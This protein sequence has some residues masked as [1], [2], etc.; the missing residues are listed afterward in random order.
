MKYTARFL[1]LNLGIALIGFSIATMLQTQ[2]GLDPWTVF[3]QGIALQTGL[4]IGRVIILTGIF[5]TAVSYFLLNIGI[6]IG[7]IL[8]ALAIGL[9]VDVFSEL[10]LA[11][12]ESFSF[13]IVECFAAIAILGFATALYITAAF[14]AGPR[15]MLVLGISKRTG[16]K[17]A[18]T[19]TFIELAA[20]L[21]GFLLGGQVGIG[22]ALFAV[23]IGWF[24][25]HSLNLLKRRQ[26]S[27]H[28]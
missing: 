4:S 5:V 12:F 28:P 26:L 13:R 7:S 21:L 17:I 15:D 20:L 1:Q 8:N 11:P 18:I 9:W 24:M 2:V 25:Q 16:Q 23:S 22:T 10:T 27:W 3:H 14:G 19:R 6:G